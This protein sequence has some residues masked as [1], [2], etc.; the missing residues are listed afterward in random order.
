M[1]NI[2]YDKT[3]FMGIFTKSK[4]M[5]LNKIKNKTIFIFISQYH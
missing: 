3:L 5:C 2:Q 1:H 4:D